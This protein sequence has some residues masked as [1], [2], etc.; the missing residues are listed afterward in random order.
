MPASA[1]A[2]YTTSAVPRP[3]GGLASAMLSIMTAN[4]ESSSCGA[5][6]GAGDGLGL[7]AGD[8]LGEGTTTPGLGDAGGLG[9]GD[10]SGAAVGGAG[11][12]AEAGCW[13]WQPATTSRMA[14]GNTK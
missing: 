14:R 2:S 7:D 4:G 5:L 1:G 10:A 12:G 13:L 6:A 8:G 11:V 3:R 9:L